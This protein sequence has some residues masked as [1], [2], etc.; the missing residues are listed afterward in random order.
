MQALNMSLKFTLR[1][2]LSSTFTLNFK[3]LQPVGYPVG[4]LFSDI[5][6]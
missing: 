6:L 2:D 4:A 5:N 3:G 1:I